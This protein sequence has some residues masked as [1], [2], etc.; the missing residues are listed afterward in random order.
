QYIN[1]I[2]SSSRRMSGLINDLLDYSRLSVNDFFQKVDLN[3]II[4][5]ILQDMEL[6][7]QE[8]KARI[9]IQQLPVIEAI[10]GQMRQLFQ[11]LISNSL[12]FTR[13]EA[14]PHISVTA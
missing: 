6:V 9:D 10:P 7:I 5:D 11:N 4:E 3:R 13:P 8:K 14:I 2:I 12:K 1:R